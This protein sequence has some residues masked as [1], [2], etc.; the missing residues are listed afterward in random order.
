[1]TRRYLAT[2]RLLFQP[3]SYRQNKTRARSCFGLPHFDSN[4]LNHPRG[5]KKGATV[6]FLV[7]FHVNV[8]CSCLV[9]CAFVYFAPRRSKPQTDKQSQTKRART[10]VCTGP[11]TWGIPAVLCSCVCGMQLSC[12]VRFRIFVACATHF[13]VRR[14]K[15]QTDKQR[16]TTHFVV[17]RSKPQTDK[18]DKQSVPAQRFARGLGHGASQQHP[19]NWRRLTALA[20]LKRGRKSGE[21]LQPKTRP[22]SRSSLC[23]RASAPASTTCENLTPRLG[24]LSLLSLSPSRSRSVSVSVSLSLFLCLCLLCLCLCLLALVGP[25][26]SKMKLCG[27]HLR[28]RP[29]WPRVVYV[30]HILSPYESYVVP[31]LD[32]RWR[33]LAAPC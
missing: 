25:I 15:P 22:P 28:P 29:S 23:S 13:V 3:I 12:G 11:G 18:H 1:M 7:L 5:K 17:R 6:L 21:P 4:R 19:P 24:R 33:R 10:E 2:L 32:R 9:M 8:E 20:S 31:M 26:L 30:G 27:A 14:S 16:Q